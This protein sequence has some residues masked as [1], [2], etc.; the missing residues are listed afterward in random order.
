VPEGC[1]RVLVDRE[2]AAERVRVPILVARQ[3]FIQPDI[4]PP[5]AGELA[6]GGA[7]SVAIE[8]ER[9]EDRDRPLGAESAVV[10]SKVKLHPVVGR[11]HWLSGGVS[12]RATY[13]A[14]MS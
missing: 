13:V 14:G 8:D 1:N 3:L 10:P 4:R 5:E 11:E 6:G 9:E 7:C 2:T 12:C